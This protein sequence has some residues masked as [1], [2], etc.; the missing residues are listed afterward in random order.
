MFFNDWKMKTKL[1]V[2]LSV[3]VA[4]PLL[5][6]GLVS[7]NLADRA[8][9]DGVKDS[10]RVQIKGFGSEAQNIV[11]TV[12]TNLVTALS[13]L[14]S[15][16]FPGYAAGQRYVEIVD[17]A[18]VAVAADEQKRNFNFDNHDFIDYVTAAVGKGYVLTIFKVEGGEA[19]RVTTSVKNAEGKRAIGTK[20]DPVVF[21]KVI[22]ARG[23]YI[24]R[25]TILGLDHFVIYRPMK[26]KDGKI[27]SIF[28]AGV[29]VDEILARFRAGVKAVKVGQ[30]GYMFIMNSKG[31][32]IVHPSKEGENISKFDFI[33]TMMKE[34]EG[35]TIYK[36]EGR[37][38]IVAYAYNETL[39][40]II[41]SGGYFSEFLGPVVKIR[42]MIIICMLFFILI[43]FILA[44][45]I[46]NTIT[47]PLSEGMGMLERMADCDLTKRLK[48]TRQDE[49]GVMTRVMDDFSEKLSGIVGQIRG[50]AEQLMA[51]TEEV[52]SSSQQIA[53]GAQQQS[54]SFEQL[55]SSVQANAENVKSANQIA[56]DVSK[57][58]KKTEQ[59]MD[60]TVQAMG[61]IEKGSKQM[62]EAVQLITEIADQTNLLALNAAIEAARAGEH[63]KGFAVVADEVRLLAERSGT[64]AKEIKNLIKENLKQVENGVT[65]SKQAGESTKVI[66]ESIKKIADQLQSVANATQE[67]AA[68]MEQNTSITES[69]A[70]ASEE[71]A[72]SAEEM[73]SQAESLRNMVS[74]FKTND[75]GFAKAS[76]SHST[77][78][79]ISAGDSGSGDLFK[80]DASFETGVEAM[81]EQH[82]KLFRMVN[83]LYRAMKEKRAKEALNGIVDDL[84]SYTAKHFQD[85]EQ[86]M[87][88]AGYPDI[89]RHKGIHKELVGKVLDVQKKLKSG[90]AT[91][92]IELLNFL[93]DWLVNHIKG[94]DKKYG[95]FIS[96]KN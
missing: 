39:D 32:L 46:A 70:S 57:E 43:G 7:Y 87:A 2:V 92:G 50:S 4:V 88:K 27:T 33:Q 20:L 12:E 90:K 19:V 53:D 23:D 91:V 13:V 78:G 89:T 55:T 3:F 17:G 64:S 62:A 73:S 80:W 8:I 65:V 86:V 36:W 77:S 79:S 74:Q 47:R 60:N 52:S 15:K 37:E 51:A 72:A 34:K 21:S 41:A 24:G 83:D 16:A 94:T 68:A 22:D 6:L 56:Q 76:A 5:V 58:V 71:L 26:N 10:L 75:A 28:F 1:L 96:G 42:T 44:W 93:K 95:S 38:K 85:E 31:D 67:Q 63:G 29:K 61:G 30:T 14:E 81:D 66:I 9:V 25:A 69:N 35:L 82:K 48:M 11:Q 84:I 54:A 49:I 18:M 59:A 40:W 45:Q